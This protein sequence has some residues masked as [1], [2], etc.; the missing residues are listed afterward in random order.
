MAKENLSISASTEI[1]GLKQIL[2][3]YAKENITDEQIQRIL[4]PV[5]QMIR[6]GKFSQPCA[7]DKTR[8]SL[9]K[10]TNTYQPQKHPPYRIAYRKYAAKRFSDLACA[11]QENLSAMSDCGSEF[12]LSKGTH[13]KTERVRTYE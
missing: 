12:M 7:D 11:L 5:I 8:Q 10:L 3:Q 4:T 13:I 6:E 2:N 1:A 9:S